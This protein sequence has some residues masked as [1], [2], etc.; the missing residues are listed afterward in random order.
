MKSTFH[1]LYNHK[2][3]LRSL[4]LIIFILVLTKINISETLEIIFEVDLIFFVMALLLFLLNFGIK[5]LRWKSLLKIQ[6]IHLSFWELMCSYIISVFLGTITPGRLGELYKIKYICHKGYSIGRASVSVLIDKMCDILILISLAFLV[7]TFPLIGLNQGVILKVLVCMFGI[8]IL[9]AFIGLYHKETFKRLTSN[10]IKAFTPTKALEKIK[11]NLNEF[12][13]DIIKTKPRKLVIPIVITLIWLLGY[14]ICNYLILLSLH[15]SIPLLYFVICIS[16]I[17]VISFLPISIS[18]I[19]TRDI[20]LIYLFSL[21]GINKESTIA[22][23]SLILFF[24]YIVNG[25]FS[26]IALLILKK[27]PRTINGNCD[28]LR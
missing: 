5:S 23:S 4:G 13:L 28:I 15:V 6:N 1:K 27:A 10:L 16:S 8:S 18:G 25:I 9:V 3:L 14:L 21:V 22:F 7:I 24:L 19:G 2:L 11:F 20:T 17:G 12:W 26:L